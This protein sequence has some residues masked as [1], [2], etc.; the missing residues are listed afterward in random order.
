M[1]S[2]GLIMERGISETMHA[3]GGP[4]QT[5]VLTP[6]NPI[7]VL[8][9]G[10]IEKLRVAIAIIGI[11]FTCFNSFQSA[12]L[13]IVSHNLRFLSDFT[14]LST[15]RSFGFNA[16]NPSGAPSSFLTQ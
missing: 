3:D 11:L 16:V 14:R 2:K 5:A 12:A 4:E 6:D 8:T 1:K 13:S 15:A 9:P 7:T 10:P